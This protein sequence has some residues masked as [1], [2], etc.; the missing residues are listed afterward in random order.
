MWNLRYGMKKP[1]S[2]QKQTYKYRD[3]TYGCQGEKTRVD[4]HWEY[5]VGRWK[6]LHLE[7][8]NTENYVQSP[9]IKQNGKAY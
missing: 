9:G 2:K 1:N 8:K 3:Q 6:L 5:G 4:V 7:W